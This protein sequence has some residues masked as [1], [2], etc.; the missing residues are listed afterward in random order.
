MAAISGLDYRVR[1]FFVATFQLM[2]ENLTCNHFASNIQW[3]EQYYY[4]IHFNW[5]NDEFIP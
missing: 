4:E 5:K 2:N 3:N 1:I